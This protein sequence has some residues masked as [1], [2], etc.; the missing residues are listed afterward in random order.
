MSNKR[1]NDQ[2]PASKDG[3][4]SA[5]PAGQP[6]GKTKPTSNPSGKSFHEGSHTRGGAPSGKGGKDL[7]SPTFKEKGHCEPSGDLPKKGA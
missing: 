3:P 4:D 5:T 6:S 7:P 1:F 2:N